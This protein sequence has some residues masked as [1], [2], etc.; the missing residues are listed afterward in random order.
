VA[1][2]LLVA[3]VAV[4]GIADALDGG[5]KPSSSGANT[6]QPETNGTTMPEASGFSGEG[7]TSGPADANV[8][9]TIYGGESCAEWD[10]TQSSSGTFWREAPFPT[11]KDEQLV[12]SMKGSGGHTLIEVRDTGEHFYGNQICASLTSEGWRNAEGPGAQ[13]EHSRQAHEAEEK[14]GAEQQAQSEHETEA[15]KRAAEQAK[16]EAQR[17]RE[18]AQQH[19]EQQAQ[20]A[21][22]KRELEKSE[23]E[24]REQ[25]RKNEEETKRIEAES[26]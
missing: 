4:G 3:L 10:R 2:A 25:D 5:S 12:C 13:V 16:E 17:R 22:S 18:E 24:V 1:F 8:R 6:S 15:R 21:Q 7:C 11:S 9:V 14:A 19:R 26:H 20:E 23:R